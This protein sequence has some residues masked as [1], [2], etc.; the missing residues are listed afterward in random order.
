MKTT[1]ST[2]CFDDSL[3]AH[4]R[5]GYQIGY[6]SILLFYLGV[7][8]WLCASGKPSIMLFYGGLML[9]PIYYSL[10]RLFSRGEVVRFTDDRIICLD[11]YG[12]VLCE[13]HWQDLQN[14]HVKQQTQLIATM[15]SGEQIGINLKRLLPAQVAQLATFAKHRL[16]GNTLNFTARPSVPFVPKQKNATMWRDLMRENMW[17][18]FN[19]LAQKLIVLSLI[20]LFLLYASINI[21][22]I[23]L[24]ILMMWIFI[25]TPNVWLRALHRPTVVVCDEQGITILGYFGKIAAQTR[26]RDLLNVRIHGNTLAIIEK[27]GRQYAFE[28]KRLHHRQ[29]KEIVAFVRDYMQPKNTFRQPENKQTATQ[30][31]F[32]A[33]WYTDVDALPTWNF[34]LCLISIAM[35]A[36]TTKLIIEPIKQFAFFKLMLSLQLLFCGLLV[37]VFYH[38]YTGIPKLFRTLNQPIVMMSPDK[39][40]F[41]V[42][43][44]YQHFKWSHI[45]EVGV[46]IKA[47]RYSPP[48]HFILEDQYGKIHRL[49]FGVYAADQTLYKWKSAILAY[50][51]QGTIPTGETPRHVEILP[52]GRWIIWLNAVLFVAYCAIYW[53]EP[54]NLLFL[55]RPSSLLAIPIV[56]LTVSTLVQKWQ[57]RVLHK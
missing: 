36:I 12:V 54:T 26:W 57:V 6:V 30:T 1:H 19:D 42:D 10:R 17:T 22:R 13:W 9:I 44:T 56:L 34:D 25:A 39:L 29:L 27:N 28:L 2:I 37:Y 18:T 40:T 45:R 15:Q 5:V 20:Q 35:L 47:G 7:M 46:H 24:F 11:Y 51:N 23:E 33:V 43:E 50:A 41:Y 52:F 48:T 8:Y 53:F 55:E 3:R 32:L 38:F 16:R 49:Q 4:L 14:I 21:Q 31:D